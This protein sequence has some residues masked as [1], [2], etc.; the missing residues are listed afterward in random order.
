MIIR[1]TL[2]IVFSEIA[3]GFNWV[4][5]ILVQ[6]FKNILGGGGKNVKSTYIFVF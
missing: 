3:S 4:G 1:Y 2:T 6:D 5:F